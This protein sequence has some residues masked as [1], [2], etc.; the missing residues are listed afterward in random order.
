MNDELCRL[1]VFMGMMIG[2]IAAFGGALVATKD[3]FDGLEIFGIGV[4]LS[5]PFIVGGLY[6]S[7]KNKIQVKEVTS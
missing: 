6:Y 3:F 2:C 1:V 4:V 5:L 7:E